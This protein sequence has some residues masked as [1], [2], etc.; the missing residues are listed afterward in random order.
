[1]IYDELYRFWE[2]EMENTEIQVLPNDFYVEL[3]RYVKRILDEKKML[4]ASSVKAHLLNLELNNVRKMSRE[5]VRLRWRKLY[6]RLLVE[7]EVN[8]EAL[9]SEEKSFYTQLIDGK[10]AFDSFVSRILDGVYRWERDTERKYLLVR[11]LK[12]VPEIVGSDLKTYG[13]FKPED[14]ATLPVENARILIKQG[15]AIKVEAR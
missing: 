15:A 12:D 3:A 8:E 5:I 13:P 4:D 9:T 6:R 7:G 14:L 2:R 10:E 11:F 1:M